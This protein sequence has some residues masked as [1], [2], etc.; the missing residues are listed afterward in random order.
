MPAKKE[1]KFHVYSGGKRISDLAGFETLGREEPGIFESLR[2]YGDCVFREKEHLERLE[3]SA[4]TTGFILT[5]D[6]RSLSREIHSAIKLFRAEYPEEGDLFLRL[7]LWRERVFVSVGTRRHAS[8]LYRDGV[9]LKTTSV[10][11]QHPA[12][13][14][15]QAKTNAY[16][17]GVMAEL[18]PD[19][20]AYEHLFLDAEGF[21]SEVSIGNIFIVKKNTLITPPCRS[22]LNGVTRLF[23]IECASS[24]KIPVLESPF[25]RHDVFNADEVFLTNTSWEILPVRELDRRRTGERVP[26]PLTSKVHRCFKQKVKRECRTKKSA[27]R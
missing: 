18:Q 25:S 4:K 15:L 5:R 2:T 9:A 11:R 7:T 3:E 24:A 12:A 1:K 8:A 10:R 26:G 20:E 6:L 22:I 23:V 14:G 16:Q 19:P 27:A 17:T 13:G 21:V